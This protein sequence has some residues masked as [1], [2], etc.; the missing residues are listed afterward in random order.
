MG[1]PDGR[2]F[3]LVF[4][5]GESITSQWH[6]VAGDAEKE[7]FVLCRALDKTDHAFFEALSWTAKRGEYRGEPNAVDVKVVI[8][9][10]SALRRERY[11]ELR[12][13][14]EAVKELVTVG[15]QVRQNPRQ[16]ARLIVSEHEA[17][18]GS[19]DPDYFG[20]HIHRN[21]SIYTNARGAV[22]SMLEFSKQV[23]DESQPFEEPRQ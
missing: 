1:E 14:E 12:R 9:P 3:W 23:W 8:S 21:V 16:H 15:V 7:L 19:A 22:R 17:V 2:T 11:Q 20:V 6:E 10:L 4:F 18:V 5:D 13:V